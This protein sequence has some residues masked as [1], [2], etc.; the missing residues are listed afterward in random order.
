MQMIPLGRY[1]TS[2]N[3]HKGPVAAHPKATTSLKTHVPFHRIFTV[4]SKESRFIKPD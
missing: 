4:I 2:T 3:P 1:D